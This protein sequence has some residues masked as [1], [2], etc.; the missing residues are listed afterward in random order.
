MA[1][2][3][4]YSTEDLLAIES[5]LDRS[6]MVCV[7]ALLAYFALPFV[8][9]A[10]P[11]E[12]GQQGVMLA[13]IMLGPLVLLPAAYVWFAVSVGRAEK[14][15]G[16]NAVLFVLWVLGAPVLSIF[17]IPI[18]STLLV[19]SPLS[20]KFLLSRELRSKIHDQTFEG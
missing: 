12:W 17:P 10:T 14:A 11:R 3:K 20:L 15:V 4:P 18:V 7:A 16:D 8:V 9:Y 19:A 6:F 13:V 5:Q 1:D 2:A